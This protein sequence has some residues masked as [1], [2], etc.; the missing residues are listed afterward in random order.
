ML[1]G[2]RVD[3]VAV[4]CD[5]ID[6]DVVGPRYPHVHNLVVV[7]NDKRELHDTLMQVTNR[8]DRVS[9]LIPSSADDD[10]TGATHAGDLVFEC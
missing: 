3:P 4:W 9:A 7:G 2:W 6:I 5:E 10:T 8:M 1:G